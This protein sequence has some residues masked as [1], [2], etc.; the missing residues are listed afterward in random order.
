LGSHGCDDV[1]DPDWSHEEEDCQRL[2]GIGP[3][4]FS[5]TLER[6]QSSASLFVTIP[7]S[8]FT[9]TPPGEQPSGLHFALEY[10]PTGGPYQPS[11]FFIGVGADEANGAWVQRDNVFGL[12]FNLSHC[13]GRIIPG[14]Y[15]FSWTWEAGF[16]PASSTSNA[17]ENNLNV[18]Y[19]DG[20][21][22]RPWAFDIL[23]DQKAAVLNFSSTPGNVNF[24][25][26][27]NGN[28]VIGPPFRQPVNQLEVVGSALFTQNVA[29][30]GNVTVAGL[31]VVT[32]SGSASYGPLQWGISDGVQLN[33]AS[34]VCAASRLGCQG[35]V[36]PNGTQLTCAQPQPQGV[37]FFALCQ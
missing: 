32:G 8:G 33:S 10:G 13:Y 37:I 18:T 28:V 17:I 2:R 31:P 34:A 21:L 20:T 6:R 35:A 16:K 23:T 27:Q 29:V 24:Q 11:E 30:S 5:G 9:A 12:C 15:D 25:I 36:L 22:H 3:H 1:K 14:L 26:N 4:C 19:S 7:D